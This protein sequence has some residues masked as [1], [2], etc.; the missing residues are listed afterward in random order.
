MT[1]KAENGEEG[2]KRWQS[3][4]AAAPFETAVVKVAKLIKT[5]R[6]V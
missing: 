5:V 4:A 6:M 2:G 1:L 3:K